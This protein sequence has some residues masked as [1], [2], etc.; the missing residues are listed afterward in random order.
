[1]QSPSHVQLFVAPWTSARQASLPLT[2][3]WSLP[4][5]MPI[6]PVMPPSLLILLP[7]PS[8]SGSFQMSQ[9]FTPGGQSIGASASASVLPMN[10]QDWFP[11]GWTGFNSFLSKRLSKIFSNTTVQQHQF[12]GALPSLWSSSHIHT[13]LLERLPWLPWPYS[14]VIYP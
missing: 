2:V 10:I 1:M 9:L 11:L 14:R 7:S 3:P 12:F 8:A 6:E 13:W 5:F 4:T